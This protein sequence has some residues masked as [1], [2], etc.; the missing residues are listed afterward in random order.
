MAKKL[1]FEKAPDGQVYYYT[2]SKVF[3]H[4]VNDDYNPVWAFVGPNVDQPEPVVEPRDEFGKNVQ[5]R[6]GFTYPLVGSKI[7]CLKDLRVPSGEIIKAGWIGEVTE[8]RYPNSDA[9][10]YYG[11][12]VHWPDSKTYK[13]GLVHRWDIASDP[14]QFSIN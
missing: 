12:C 4:R 6:A 5:P 10:G 8:N 3:V 7:H 1:G 2:Q 9:G 14:E 13:F 11:L